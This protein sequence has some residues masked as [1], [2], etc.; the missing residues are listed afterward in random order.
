MSNNP[1]Q[2]Y[3]GEYDHW[4]DQHRPAYLSELEA[5]RAALP[6]AGVGLEIGVGTGR[7]AG[8][9]SIEWGI[10]PAREMLV[11]AR[12]RGVKVTRGRGETV[13]FNSRSFDYVV[14][15]TVLCFLSSPDRVVGEAHRV[16]KDEGRLILGFVDRESYLGRIYQEKKEK[17]RFYSE[18]N[19][20]S[21]PD[22][23]RL[24]PSVVW[25][26]ISIRQTLFESAGERDAV[27]TPREGYG[28]G[29][30][31]VISANTHINTDR[32]TGE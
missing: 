22:V 7:F 5:L 20:Y 27:Q 16:L 24:L 25:R 2:S 26:K 9:L 32:N 17:S 15:V 31:V 3:P 8:P 4:Y 14:M 10:D 30:F 28:E 29:G 6:S 21:V 1:Y 23:L 13:P 19:F 12:E 18:A 11:R